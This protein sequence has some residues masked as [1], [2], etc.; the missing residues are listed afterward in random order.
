ML[1]SAKPIYPYFI[2]PKKRKI[3]DEYYNIFKIA[4]EEF[5]EVEALLHFGLSSTNSVR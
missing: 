1:K 2:N 4:K 3:Q 5:I